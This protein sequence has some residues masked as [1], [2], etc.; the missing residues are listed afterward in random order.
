MSKILWITNP[1]ISVKVES[2]FLP[3]SAWKRDKTIKILELL[4]KNEVRR[5]ITI[6]WTDFTSNIKIITDKNFEETPLLLPSWIDWVI[7]NTTKKAK[8]VLPVADCAPI[9]AYHKSWEICG[10]F[11]AGYK[12]VAWEE[13]SDLWIITTMVENLKEVSNS[14]DLKDFE[15]Y[16]WPMIWKKFELPKE[17]VEKIFWRIFKE[18]NLKQEK[19]FLKHK[20]DNTKVYLYLKLLIRDILEKLWK[21]IRLKTHL[22]EEPSFFDNENTDNW[23]SEYPS[24][25]LYT[26]FQTNDEEVKKLYKELNNFTLYLNS[27]LPN[28]RSVLSIKDEIKEIKRKIKSKKFEQYKKDYRLATILEN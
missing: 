13:A 4:Q 8:L 22:Q 12:W 9:I 16:I 18:Y 11:H 1:D 3:N 15:F 5:I 20:T 17:Y 7:L 21:R 2:N 23:N 14:D 25:R 10:S 26:K 6:D 27:Y 24:H 28:D 19:Y